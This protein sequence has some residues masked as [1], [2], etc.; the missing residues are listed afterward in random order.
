MPFFFFFF[1]YE[2]TGS[3][4]PASRLVRCLSPRSISSSDFFLSHL[5]VTPCS[6]YL[7]GCSGG[8]EV[9]SR[10]CLGFLSRLDWIQYC[11]LQLSP[12]LKSFFF[13]VTYSRSLLCCP[14]RKKTNKNKQKTHTHTCILF[15]R[16]YSN[17]WKYIPSIWGRLSHYGGWTPL[18]GLVRS[19]VRRD[20]V[21][22]RT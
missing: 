4:W 8:L 22:S 5:L 15:N 9:S 11:H 6:S 10:S 3:C 18:T 19:L 21:W 7:H 13:F 17:L 12:C 2:P 20:N 1:R 14:R 16:D